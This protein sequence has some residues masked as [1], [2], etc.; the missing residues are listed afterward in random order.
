[1]N[2]GRK[3]LGGNR[4]YERNKIWATIGFQEHVDMF[5]DKSQYELS[6]SGPRK[7]AGL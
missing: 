4:I 3:R 2:R 6:G 5:Y 7:G 1:M